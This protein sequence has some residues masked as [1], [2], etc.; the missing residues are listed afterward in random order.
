ML[1]ICIQFNYIISTIMY[2]IIIV[3]FHC[4]QSLK[5]TFLTYHRTQLIVINIHRVL[6]CILPEANNNGNSGK[7]RV[8]IC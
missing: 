1:I 6:W 2:T 7:R 5:C 8:D 4:T 3:L